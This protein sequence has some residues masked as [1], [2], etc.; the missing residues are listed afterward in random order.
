MPSFLLPLSRYADF[1]GRARRAEYWQFYLAQLVIFVVLLV[2]G[3]TSKSL[4]GAMIMMP[5]IGV[6]LLALFVPN[7][8]VTVRRLH[9]SNRSAVWLLLY[10]PALINGAMS[11]FNADPGSQHHATH[12][13]LSLISGLCNLALLVLMCLR[14]T[15]GTNRYGSDPKGGST[16]IAR[17][18]DAPA[19]ETSPVDEAPYKPVFDFG[20]TGTT[21]RREEP[22]AP[23][24]A[25]ETPPPPRPAAPPAFGAPARP[26]FG[27]R[28]L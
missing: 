28:G 22:A 2:L 24:A 9:D 12:P 21:Q 7:L 4:T 16:D 23:Q 17:V 6:I 11:G 10:V 26:A 8:A 3:F 20:P 18:F 15:D 25:R 27:K 13:L 1:N 14:G 5:V 19:A